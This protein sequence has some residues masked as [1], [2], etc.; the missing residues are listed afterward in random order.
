MQTLGVGEEVLLG[1]L[2]YLMYSIYTFQKLRLQHQRL[3]EWV[4]KSG[5][6]SELPICYHQEG[7]TA[8]TYQPLSLHAGAG[9][10]R[11]A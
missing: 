5:R 10:F 11:L 3:W 7:P 9:E 4:G 8:L 1:V 6:A 2:V